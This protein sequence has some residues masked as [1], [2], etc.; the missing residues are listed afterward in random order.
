[1]VGFFERLYGLAHLSARLTLLLSNSASLGFGL[2]LCLSVCLRLIP[3]CSEGRHCFG[4]DW[5]EIQTE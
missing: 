5:K 2:P 1:M 4:L 3:H